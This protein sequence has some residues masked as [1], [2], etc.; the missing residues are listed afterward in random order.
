[1][2]QTHNDLGQNDTETVCFPHL[3]LQS[4]R[5]RWAEKAFWR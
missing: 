1:M 5:K 4:Q 2:E 3:L